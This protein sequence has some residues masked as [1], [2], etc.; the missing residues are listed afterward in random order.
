MTSTIPNS[1]LSAQATVAEN[2]SRTRWELPCV[3]TRVRIPLGS[4]SVLL[5]RNPLQQRIHSLSQSAS[6]K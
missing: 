4:L 2:D 3:K 5:R 6:L 1:P